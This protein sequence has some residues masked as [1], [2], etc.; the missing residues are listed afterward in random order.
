MFSFL[1]L[2][3]LNM[4]NVELAEARP[5]MTEN[6]GF[7]NP[8]LHHSFSVLVCITVQVQNFVFGM[9]FHPSLFFCGL[10]L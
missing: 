7:Q 5:V 6:E 8:L 9:P 2:G 10:L 3:N 1:C 4:S